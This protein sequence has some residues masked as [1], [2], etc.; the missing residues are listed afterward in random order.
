MWAF[1]DNCRS[2]LKKGE[3]ASKLKAS[4]LVQLYYKNTGGQPQSNFN[5]III[6]HRKGLLF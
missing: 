1:A 5:P 4:L 3:V 2:G 6:N